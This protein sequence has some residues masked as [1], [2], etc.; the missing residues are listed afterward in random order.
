[1]ARVQFDHKNC[2]KL[3]NKWPYNFYFYFNCMLNYDTCMWFC[4][5]HMLVYAECYEMLC[6]WYDMWILCFM[7]WIDTSTIWYAK[8]R[9]AWRHTRDR[10]CECYVT[11]MIYDTVWHVH[12]MNWCVW[13]HDKFMI[14]HMF[15]MNDKMI[16]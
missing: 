14:W 15:D 7:W 5:C 16:W 13:R 6:A 10:I 9:C 8:L 4:T 12:D 2:L 11:A 1:M 3:R